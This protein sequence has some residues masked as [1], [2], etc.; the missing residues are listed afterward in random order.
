VSYVVQRIVYDALNLFIVASGVDPEELVTPNAVRHAGPC[1]A[2][3]SGNSKYFHPTKAVQ[4]ICPTKAVQE[5]CPMKAVQEKCYAWLRT[6]LQSQDT[7]QDSNA[8]RILID[9]PVT[10]Q[11]PCPHDHVLRVG[12][13]YYNGQVFWHRTA[14]W[15]AYSPT[16]CDESLG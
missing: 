2:S 10:L 5:I 4:E 11:Y 3:A 12:A 9:F 8:S 15:S 7:T 13:I 6:S 16:S 14:R 1:Q